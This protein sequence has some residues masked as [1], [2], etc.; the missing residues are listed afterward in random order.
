M[1]CPRAVARDLFDGQQFLAQ[2]LRLLDLDG[3]LFGGLG[4]AVQEVEDRVLYL[5]HELAA[6]LGIAELV[7]CLRLE[8]R[9]LQANGDGRHDALA[10][11][12][13]LVA[14]L[15]KFV[16]RLEYAFTTGA[17]MRAAITRILPVHERKVGFAEALRMRKRD[18]EGF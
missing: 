6:N 1:P 3:G 7:L 13:A 11:V 2:L 14:L 18:L 16:D 12:I 5:R 8:D 17:E 15:R 10:H 9:I 4:V